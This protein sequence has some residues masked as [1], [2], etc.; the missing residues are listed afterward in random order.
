MI[1]K[2]W[3][4]SYII[5]RKNENKKF[6]YEEPAAQVI[7]FTAEDI[8]TTSGDLDPAELEEIED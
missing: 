4:Q 7:K 6:L 2:V 8:I 5:R 1:A 3:N